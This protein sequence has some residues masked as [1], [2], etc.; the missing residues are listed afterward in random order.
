M[1]GNRAF[2]GARGLLAV[3]KPEGIT[4]YDVVRQIKKILGSVKIGHSGTLDPFASG[5]LVILLGEATKINRFLDPF[6][7]EYEFEMELGI[8]TDT[9]DMTGKLVKRTEVPELTRGQVET[10]LE[11]FRG[12]ISQV[13]PRFSAVNINGERAYKLAA[14]GVEFELKSRMVDI[15]ALSLLGFEPPVLFLRAVVSKGTY[16]R[17]LARDLGEA[18]GSVATV[19]A[20]RRTRIGPMG[21]SDTVE[22]A[23]LSWETIRNRL[24]PIDEAL[25][26]LPTVTLQTPVKEKFLQGQSINWEETEAG[27]ESEERFIRVRDQDGKMLVIGRAQHGRLKPYRLIYA[28]N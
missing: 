26:N 4:S 14:K 11:R 23:G 13:P 1:E 2:Y 6:E 25:S 21:L 27:R 10:V 8:E 15:H 22:L 20:L 12:R 28:D 7:K 9:L 3:N 24:V 19:R 18:L 16:I 5:V 17:A